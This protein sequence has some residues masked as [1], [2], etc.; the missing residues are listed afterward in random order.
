MTQE[1]I[2]LIEEAMQSKEGAF[3]QLF[4][5]YY[6]MAYAMAMRETKND[7]DAKDAVQEAFISIHRS[8]NELRDPQAF[9]AWLKTIVHSKCYKLFR[10]KHDI[11]ADPNVM[12]ETYCVEERSYMVPVTHYNNENE[13]EVIHQ[14]I[15]QLKPRYQEVVELVYL[16]QLKIEEAAN[17][18]GLSAG[19]VKTR[20]H[21][22]K[23]DLF[24]LVKAFEKENNRKIK[25]KADALAADSL[26]IVVFKQ[27]K[28]QLLQTKEYIS[29][30]LLTS[31]CMA[32]MSVLM[33][34]GAA[35]VYDDMK[36]AKK[37]ED[38]AQIQEKETPS[39]KTENIDLNHA[40]FKAKVYQDMNITNS[41][42]A[43][44]TCVNFIMNE[45]EK[46]QSEDEWN[47]ILPVYYALKDKN[48]A[49]YQLLKAE[50][51]TEAFEQR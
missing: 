28:Q 39:D 30:N 13:K 46:E 21:R 51:Y 18:L 45:L 38:T 25:F 50:G 5:Y 3:E 33:V 4:E 36:E 37:Q 7:A 32:S 1:E 47:E 22:A 35:F 2:R 26:L 12:N 15:K 17:L 48:D 23:K 43:Y 40:V 44:Y 42:S 31:A 41:R 9:P 11:P 24:V 16:K 8:I 10:K 14:L 20:L 49:Y 29:G 27:M 6:S 19:T 34:S